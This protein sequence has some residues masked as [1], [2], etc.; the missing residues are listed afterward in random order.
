MSDEPKQSSKK[1]SHVAYFVQEGRDG[2][3][4]F[5]RI[6]ASF[7]HKDGQGYDVTVG[8]LPV[9]GRITLRTPK[10]RLD[11]MENGKTE[12]PQQSQDKGE[13]ER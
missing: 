7:A 12:K 3:S 1:P 9:N 8:A 11:S 6:G 13:Q 2:E 4:Y 5:N 10:E